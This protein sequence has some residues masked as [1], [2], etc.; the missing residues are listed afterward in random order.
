MGCSGC[1]RKSNSRGVRTRKENNM[2]TKKDYNCKS[3]KKKFKSSSVFEKC[4]YCQEPVAPITK[5][6]TTTKKTEVKTELVE[7]TEKD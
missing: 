5:K 4:P 3:C 2:R 7:K 6:K 1:S